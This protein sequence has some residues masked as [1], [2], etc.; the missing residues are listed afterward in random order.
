MA[1]PPEEFIKDLY[2]TLKNHGLEKIVGLR[3]VVGS[4]E[5]NSWETTPEGARANITRYGMDLPE[6]TDELMM[7][8]VGFVF[9]EKGEIGSSGECRGHQTCGRHCHRHWQ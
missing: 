7:I 1:E 4:K 8:K 5:T 2:E 6:E 3:R 9:N